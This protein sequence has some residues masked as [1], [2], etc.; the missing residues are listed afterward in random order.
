[1][2]YR[3]LGQT[4]LRVSVI[5]MGTWQFGGEWG[6]TFTQEQVTPLF[7]KALEL[8]INFIDTAECYGDHLS[9]QF[10]GQALHDLHARAQF[11]LATKFG[12][13]FVAPFN[14]T[15]PRSGPEV[16]E[17]LDASLQALQTD[18]IDLYQYHSWGDAQFEDDGVRVV[19]EK[20]QQAGK[21]RHLGNS[22][23]GSVKTPRQIEQSHT[24]HVEAIQLVY[25]RLQQHAADHLFP[26][27]ERLHLGVL[28]RVPLASG[29]LSGKYRPGAKFAE[30]DVRTQWQAAG[31]DQ[32]LVEVQRI[33]QTEVP[34]GVP[35]ARWALAWCLTS[36]A[37]QCVIPGCKTP[38]QVE[39]NARAADL[40]LVDPKHPW[41]AKT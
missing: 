39:D 23:P 19:L 2:K 36:P 18:Y 37:V 35:M 7:A 28:A 9:E 12:H 16:A 27:C 25:N 3:T 41:A 33:A 29:L 15:E 6:I 38:Q 14:R 17:Q 40:D 21:I 32:R 8:G 34:P 22:L 26:V 11:I 13:H 24:F 31:I 4:N 1:M 20:A 30:N 5:G 10:I